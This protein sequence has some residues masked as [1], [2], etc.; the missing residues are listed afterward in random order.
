[1]GR[2]AG[3]ANRAPGAAKVLIY[4]PTSPEPYVTRSELS[5]QSVEM[6]GFLGIGAVIHCY[7]WSPKILTPDSRHAANLR[8]WS[9]CGHTHTRNPKLV[10]NL[11]LWSS[12][13]R[14]TYNGYPYPNPKP[15]TNCQFVFVVISEVQGLQR[16]QDSDGTADRRG[17][18]K[19]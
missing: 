14:R 11:C 5:V 17:V 10:V 16:R 12:Q 15:Q 8:L 2:V 9:S 3:I 7:C 4:G 18:H 13:R 1:M 6:F 19:P